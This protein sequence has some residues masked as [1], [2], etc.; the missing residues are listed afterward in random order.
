MVWGKYAGCFLSPYYQET[1]LC[2]GTFGH[3]DLVFDPCNWRVVSYVR[4][5]S[6]G[7]YFTS[8]LV[9]LSLLTL[10]PGRRGKYTVSLTGMVGN[11]MTWLE[12]VPQTRN[13]PV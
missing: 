8:L 4:S 3:P 6:F 7:I 13:K 2:S 9:A 12:S 10:P 11:C 1:A 5:D